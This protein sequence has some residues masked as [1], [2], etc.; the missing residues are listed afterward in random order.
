MKH[1]ALSVLIALAG[2]MLVSTTPQ[3]GVRWISANAEALSAATNGSAP[4]PA[5]STAAHGTAAAVVNPKYRIGVGDVLQIAVWK[6]PDASVPTVQVRSDGA[7]TIPFVRNIEVGGL[8]LAEAEASI[9]QKL[10]RYVQSPDVTVLVREINSEKIYI[11]GAVRHEGA[12][13]LKSTTN[14]LQALAEAGGLTDY[15]KRKKIY[16]LRTEAKGQVRLPFNYEDVIV[17]RSVQQ[18]VRLRAGDT[19]VVPQ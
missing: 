11:L 18:N 13:P 8:T 7:I 4:S 12:M 9:A 14:V 2:P 10:S 19:V 6:E 15:A 1:T 16:V 17:G 5:P 3:L